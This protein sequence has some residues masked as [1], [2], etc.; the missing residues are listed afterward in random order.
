MEMLSVLG[1]CCLKGVNVESNEVA[2]ECCMHQS[3]EVREEMSVEDLLKPE[4]PPSYIIHRPHPEDLN[5]PFYTDEHGLHFLYF[6]NH[7]PIK[8]NPKVISTITKDEFNNILETH[9]I[10]INTISNC[11]TR[12]I[13]IDPQKTQVKPPYDYSTD[14][15]DSG[16]KPIHT[17][18]YM[19]NQC[20]EK[21]IELMSN[22]STLNTKCTPLFEQLDNNDAMAPKALD[23]NSKQESHK[24]IDLC[25]RLISIGSEIKSQVA[26]NLMLTDT[27][28]KLCNN[29]QD[30]LAKL[31]ITVQQYGCDSTIKNHKQLHKDVSE[32]IYN[33]MGKIFQTISD[34]KKTDE[35]HD[36][37]DAG[38]A[39]NL[40]TENKEQKTNQKKNKKEMEK[41]PGLLEGL[42]QGRGCTI[43]IKEN[44]SNMKCCGKQNSQKIKLHGVKADAYQQTSTEN[45]TDERLLITKDSIVLVVRNMPTRNRNNHGHL[46]QA[47]EAIVFIDDPS[48]PSS[49]K[50][51]KAGQKPVSLSTEK[52]YSLVSDLCGTDIDKKQQPILSGSL[53]ELYSANIANIIKSYTSSKH[54]VELGSPENRSNITYTLC[55]PKQDGADTQSVD[56]CNERNYSWALLVNE[57]LQKC[58]ADLCQNNI[59]QKTPQN[60]TRMKALHSTTAAIE[61]TPHHQV[62][63]EIHAQPPHITGTS[64]V[65]YSTIYPQCQSTHL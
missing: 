59:G 27:T 36:T 1:G 35:S 10:D 20:T 48:D 28:L 14:E 17:Q 19:P 11:S 40:N 47:I 41:N 62:E 52:Y 29:M 16:S 38:D 50:T 32:Q 18:S 57:G 60:D 15:T 7:I 34:M 37:T 4:T 43:D 12:S 2:M 3:T 56:K 9:G 22:I 26:A 58:F 63:S 53:D 21:A 45:N 49:H 25:N 55:T 46:K 31:L 42:F 65:P 8:D 13:Y 44:K 33:I 24:I 61:Y 51:R 6:G 5:E 23:D 54:E 64:A 30:T 39:L